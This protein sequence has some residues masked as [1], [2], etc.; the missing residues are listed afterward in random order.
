MLKHVFSTTYSQIYPILT[1][2]EISPIKR[3]QCK[4]LIIAVQ[5]RKKQTTIK[6]K[7]KNPIKQKK[8]HL[9]ATTEMS[10]GSVTVHTGKRG[11]EGRNESSSSEN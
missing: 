1:Y 4:E 8:N 6:P 3:M 5:R 2:Q 10:S 7:E 11:T 9:K